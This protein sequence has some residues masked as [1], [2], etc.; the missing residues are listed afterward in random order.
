MRDVTEHPLPEL[1]AWNRSFSSYPRQLFGAG[2]CHVRPEREL[3]ALLVGKVEERCEHAGREL[4]RH[5]I[6]PLEGLASRQ[7]VQNLDD[8]LADQRLE[9]FQV[10]RRC[11]G[12]NDLTVRVVPLSVHRDEAGLEREVGLGVTQHDAARRGEDFVVLL[13]LDDVVEAR[14][15]PVGA[16]LTRCAVVDRIILAQPLEES[17]ER[18][19]LEE[20]RTKKSDS[21]R[22]S[23]KGRSVKSLI[24]GEAGA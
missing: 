5:P 9:H 4:D 13:D 22:S 11:H 2:R 10:S 12:L 15:R 8:S 14:D 1:R 19:G 3:A 7:A 17:P 21:A 20:A 16:E 24:G 23:G 18:V 6:D